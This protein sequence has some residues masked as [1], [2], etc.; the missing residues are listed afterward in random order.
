MT[1]FNKTRGH[2][3]QP[4]ESRRRALVLLLA[5]FPLVTLLGPLS[6]L[7]AGVLAGLLFP[8]ALKPKP[9]ERISH[10]YAHVSCAVFA[11]LILV[12]HHLFPGVHESLTS[13]AAGIW[14]SIALLD[15]AQQSAYIAASLIVPFYA[16]GTLWHGPSVQFQWP[17]RKRRTGI[18]SLVLFV[19]APAG[20]LWISLRANGPV[21]SALLL[22]LAPAAGY[23]LIL[24]I[25]R[26]VARHRLARRWK[27]ASRPF[28]VASDEGRAVL[29]TR[30][31]L[32]DGILAHAALCLLKTHAGDDNVPVPVRATGPIIAIE[33]GKVTS[34]PLLLSGAPARLLFNPAQVCLDRDPG[35]GTTARYIRTAFETMFATRILDIDHHA[36]L[37]KGRLAETLTLIL[38]DAGL[39][40][41]VAAITP[42]TEIRPDRTDTGLKDSDIGEATHTGALIL[43]DGTVANLALCESGAILISRGSNMS[44]TYEAVEAIVSASCVPDTAV[45]ARDY[46]DYRPG[47]T[48]LRNG[49]SAHRALVCADYVAR[50]GLPA[51]DLFCTPDAKMMVPGSAPRVGGMPYLENASDWPTC[52]HSGLPL[53]FHSQVHDLFAPPGRKA[54]LLQ[55]FICHPQCDHAMSFI[56]EIRMWEDY[57]DA[58]CVRS[59]NAPEPSHAWRLDR[60]RKYR[61]ARDTESGLAGPVDLPKRPPEKAPETREIYVCLPKDHPRAFGFDGVRIGGA[62]IDQQ[63]SGGP[64]VSVTGDWTRG[65]LRDSRHIMSLGTAPFPPPYNARVQNYP[66]VLAHFDSPLPALSAHVSYD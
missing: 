17:P 12:A 46:C 28:D 21:D 2:N 20:F 1:F 65:P 26:H 8:L 38:R 39:P 45:P 7:P 63:C 34:A 44:I 27:N 48:E 11:A 35:R 61:T 6:A 42:I 22:T 66:I 16:A 52:P 64:I 14:P 37:A 24:S 31:K 32:A 3:P 9:A 10:G 57:D 58:R 5:I 62:A 53:V 18:A 30:D 49:V 40:L 15:P 13:A 55:L 51:E 47:P 43:A 54:P 23:L 56:Q 36:G 59:P 4:P 19:L 50:N 33:D 60:A 25:A 29:N 41:D